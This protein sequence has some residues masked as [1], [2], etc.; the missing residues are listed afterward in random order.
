MSSAPADDLLRHLRHLEC[1]LHRIETRRDRHRVQ[2]LLHPDFT[3][4]GRSGRRYDRDAILDE[5]AAEGDLP[6][7]HT[8]NFALAELAPGV[9]LL[10]YRSAHVD[11]M[12]KLSSESE[13]CSIWVSTAAGWQLRYH[14]GTPAWDS[15][16]PNKNSTKGVADGTEGRG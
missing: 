6:L 3:E 1:E 13:R 12:G 16:R 7:F 8:G 2:E 15:A 11:S 9:V 4:V 14:Q 5:L 10:T